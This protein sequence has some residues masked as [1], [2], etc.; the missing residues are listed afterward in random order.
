[1][2]KNIVLQLKNIS[3]SFG[4]VHANKNISLDLYEGEIL[5]LLGENGSGKTSLMNILSGIYF[6][7]NGKIL[8]DGKKITIT[9]PRDAFNYK[10]GMVHQHFKLVDVFTAVENVVLGLTKEDF[11]NFKQAA[12]D[13]A[14]EALLEAQKE[15]REPTEAEQKAYQDALNV[16]DKY[17]L[18]DS[19]K[20]ISAICKKYGFVLDLDK[21]VCDMSVSEKQTLEIIKVLYRGVDLLILDEPT[22]VLT[23]QEI[24]KLFNVVRKM[25]EDGKSIIIIT[26][27]LNE[28][29]EISDRI[30]VLRKGEL[31]GSVLKEETTIEELT[32]MMV[33]KKTELNIN[34]SEPKG[35]EKILEVRHVY[36]KNM[37]GNTILKN[38]T[39]DLKE[40]EILG[41]AG[42]SGSGQ[43]ELLDAI[44]GVDSISKGEV[45][46][47]RMKKG[48]PL[49]LY[50]KS[51]EEIRKLSDIGAFVDYYGNPI[52]FV[53]EKL[54]VRMGIKRN[55]KM[56]AR[57]IRKIVEKGEVYFRDNETMFL[58]GKNPQEIRELGIHL[59]F[60]PEDR[61]GMG[62]VPGMSIAD[63]VM[64]RTYKSGKTPFLNRR[65]PRETSEK[66]V[67]DLEIATP[68]IDIQVKKLS[69]GNLQK[70]LVGREIEYSPSVFMV[71]YPVRGLDINSSYTIYN[72]LNK[73]KENGVGILYIGEDLDVL[74]ELCDRI[75]VLC[76]GEV[77]GIVDART[78]DKRTLGALM[79]GKSL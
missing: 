67:E 6:P 33:G 68:S 53:K 15:G 1:M 61:L 66:M 14:Q 25:K 63:N 59:A 28:V 40:G 73:Q 20:K 79:V 4:K 31:I 72:L 52:T 35:K 62:L 30:T 69:G 60:V 41:V 13:E 65:L 22:A 12:I 71:A 3:K 37:A 7:D 58:K 39:F 49:T 36:V 43:K 24:D 74:L 47:H 18:K 55:V 75:L 51:V 9:S 45:V 70:V 48:K 27:K 50:H 46:Y 10:I 11:K 57:E 56:S 64:L 38:I 77:S 5:S 17:N 42:I 26:H 29:M 34:R 16:S 54:D 32:E 78:T 44:A 23:P 21:R 19:E 2:E 76:D 8:L